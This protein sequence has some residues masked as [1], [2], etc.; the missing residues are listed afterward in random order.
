MIADRV[1]ESLRVGDFITIDPNQYIPADILLLHS[2]C[3]VET[4]Q[5]DGETTLK[6]KVPIKEKID[7]IDVPGP[8]PYLYQFNGSINGTLP[9]NE[10]N[11][12][13]R[14]S[15]LKSLDPI[16]GVVIYTGHQTKIMLNSHNPRGKVTKMQKLMNKL[17]LLLFL[18]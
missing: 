15:C 16:D 4:S 11:L 17:I 12:L 10:Q 3:F 9:L 1:A 14:G 6:S 2:E 7:F 18:G 13:L 8:N 5:L